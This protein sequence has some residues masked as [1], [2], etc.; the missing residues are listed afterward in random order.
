MITMSKKS[1]ITILLVWSAL[2]V[3]LGYALTSVDIGNSLVAN[4]GDS[5]S[6]L[7]SAGKY[8]NPL[9]EC[10]IARDTIESRKLDFSPELTS[11]VNDIEATDG[12]VSMS[13]YYRDLNNGPISGVNQSDDFSPASLLKVPIMMAYLEHSE[14]DPSILST[15]YSID[16]LDRSPI[17]VTQTIPPEQVLVPKI[18]YTAKE[19]IEHM[20]KYSDNAAMML[21]YKH[22]PT[23]ELKDLFTLMGVDP[24]VVSDATKKISVRQYSIFFR[25]LFNASYLSRVDSEYA[26]S[27]LAES[28]FDKGLHAG[29][30]SGV[31]I[32][33]KFGER[34]VDTGLQQL[35]DCGIVYY[36]KHPYLLCMMTRGSDVHALEKA[37]AK[38]SAFVYK[39]IDDQYR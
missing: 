34:R 22:M 35:H 39:K 2:M 17:D 23:D 15:T 24:D 21:L 36:P 30:P 4:A 38:T 25:I 10:N 26:L 20:I 9:L 18:Q 28:N 37:L 16:E 7:R 1:R 29:V 31:P 27:L 12:V 11:L 14:K 5:D 32:A 3:G 33:H 13:V 8:T 19:L 6:E